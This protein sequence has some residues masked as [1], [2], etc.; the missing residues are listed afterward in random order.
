MYQEQNSSPLEMLCD[1]QSFSKLQWLCYETNWNVMFSLCTNYS[2]D[3]Q[4]PLIPD[5]STDEVTANL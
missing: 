1:A 5:F 4:P 2:I 3:T